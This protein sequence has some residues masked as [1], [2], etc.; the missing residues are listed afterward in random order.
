MAAILKF[1][2]DSDWSIRLLLLYTFYAYN[3]KT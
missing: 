1:S 2:T 3:F